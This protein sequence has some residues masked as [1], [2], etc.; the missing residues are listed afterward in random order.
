MATELGVFYAKNYNIL[1]AFYKRS[2]VITYG[3]ILPEDIVIR[4]WE[5]QDDL[6]TDTKR[7]SL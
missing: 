2:D 6:L 5:I 4:N 7:C 3:L 1:C